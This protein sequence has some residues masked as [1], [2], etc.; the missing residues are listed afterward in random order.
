MRDAAP[1]ACP[2][3]RTAPAATRATAKPIGR[4]A[5]AVAAAAA[6]PPVTDIHP[7]AA[8]G[9]RCDTAP[10][11]GRGR[12]GPGRAGEKGPV[13]REAGLPDVVVG[14]V[15]APGAPSDLAGWLIG[16]LGQ[17]M[18]A[19]HAD[20]RW[21]VR[22]MEDSVVQPP[23]D[24]AEIVAA[25]RARLLTENWDLAIC[26]TDLPLAADRRPVVAHASPVHGVA[27]LSLPALGAVGV[28]RWAL[29]TTQD[30]IRALLGTGA[31]SDPAGLGHRVRQ[32]AAD[33]AEPVE[34]VHRLTI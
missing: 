17:Q 12:A 4:T 33:P 13:L 22:C 26:L 19:E 14:L 21:D 28:R 18:S 1:A 10:A 20:V 16:A 34:R 32:L 25:V 5:T 15:A 27:V 29:Q 6:D 30:L 8:A 31:A 3:R 2:R 9:G 11:T 24:D 7:D 23:A